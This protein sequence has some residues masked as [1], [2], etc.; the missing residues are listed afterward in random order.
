MCIG[1]RVTNRSAPGAA[2]NSWDGSVH[3]GTYRVFPSVEWENFWPAGLDGPF[4]S[5]WQ[6]SLN[7]VPDA[8][9]PESCA[10]EMCVNCEGGTVQSKVLFLAGSYNE[11]PVV[12][13]YGSHTFESGGWRETIFTSAW[14][15]VIRTGSADANAAV[16]EA[17]F[18]I[19]GWRNVLTALVRQAVPGIGGHRCVTY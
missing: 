13:A 19:T 3:L 17:L 10:V 8:C 5:F 14:D 11:L 18:L 9:A 6:P 2:V 15:L 1:V 12:C 4:A 7:D 16:T